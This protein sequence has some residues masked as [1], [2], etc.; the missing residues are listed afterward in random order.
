MTVIRILKLSYIGEIILN[1]K[2]PN[3]KERVV[4]EDIAKEW[5]IQ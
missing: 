3:N 4:E 1:F 2:S 5:D